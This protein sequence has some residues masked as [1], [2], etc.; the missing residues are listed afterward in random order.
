MDDE[1][2]PVRRN[3]MDRDD[4]EDV[5]PVVA[6]AVMPRPVTPV[7]P[8]GAATTASGS[9]TPPAV[10]TNNIPRP[11]TGGATVGGDANTFYANIAANQESRVEEHWIKSYW[12]PAMGWLYMLICL[13]DF[14]VFPALT[15]ILPGIL[16]GFG[17]AIIYTPWQSLSL[18]SGGL[19]H[20]SFAAIL[21]VA[22]WSRGQ[23]KINDKR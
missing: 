4:D 5:A 9:S 8:N 7:I 22:A 20:L 16:K 12:R 14:V 17:V 2:M 15:M 23:E 6:P 13:M 1:E 11:S 19:I 3:P 10:N 18:S 21:G